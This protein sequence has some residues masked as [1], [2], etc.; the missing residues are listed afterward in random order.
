[1]PQWD[2]KKYVEKLRR[3]VG[4]LLIPYI[5]WNILYALHISWPGI[6]PLLNGTRDLG[7]WWERLQNLGGWHIFWDCRKTGLNFPCPILV[8]LWFIRN[9]M[10]LVLAA[11]LIQW[12]IKKLRWGGVVVLLG[13]W[14]VSGKWSILNNAIYFAIGAS[15]CILSFDL[16]HYCRRYLLPIALVTIG[17]LG[18]LIYTAMNGIG[19]ECINLPINHV[20]KI[21]S[22]LSV[23]GLA[24]L[25][26]E[27]GWVRRHKSLEKASM[28]IYMSHI[29]FIK[30]TMRGVKSLIPDT[31][32]P[33]MALRYF[34]IPIIVVTLCTLLYLLWLK[35]K[36]INCEE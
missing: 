6:H 15:C 10:I 25:L 34:L 9:L 32:F 4:T 3:R 31:N 13:L 1:M 8:P 20:Y 27:M 28:F 22:I 36:K 35:V 17:V 5:C 30:N 21:A 11:P 16:C 23:I 7:D 14:I 2:K 19:I 33:L 24:T 29:F 26:N 18:Y 12:L